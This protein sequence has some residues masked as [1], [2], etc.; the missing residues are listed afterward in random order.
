MAACCT[1]CCATSPRAHKEER[2]TG[3]SAPGAAC[4]GDGRGFTPPVFVWGGGSSPGRLFYLVGWGG[5]VNIWA[6]SSHA[7]QVQMPCRPPWKQTLAVYAVIETATSTMRVARY[8]VSASGWVERFQVVASRQKARAYIPGF[9]YVRSGPCLGG[10]P[11]F[12]IQSEIHTVFQ[13]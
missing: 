4:G 8:V 6:G 3:A 10:F 9:P 13:F 12:A 5:G 7:L 11:V 1:T 2:N